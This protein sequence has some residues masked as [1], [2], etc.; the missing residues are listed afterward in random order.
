MDVLGHGLARRKVAGVGSGRSHDAG[1]D[2]RNIDHDCLHSSDREGVAVQINR[3]FI[4]GNGDDIQ[5]G[6]AAV[7]HLRHLDRLAARHSRERRHAST[8]VWDH[9]AKDQVRVEFQVDEYRP[10]RFASPAGEK[11]CIGVNISIG[12]LMGVAD[13]ADHSQ[14]SASIDKESGPAFRHCPN[15]RGPL[16]NIHA[17]MP[18][19]AS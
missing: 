12:D 10:T 15:F 6:C 17:E 4:L 11:D 5:H 9:C 13:V 19:I 16:S 7:A 18:H 1:V 3:G 8:S 14:L 2:S